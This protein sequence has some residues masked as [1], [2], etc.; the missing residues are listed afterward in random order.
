MTVPG[1]FKCPAESLLKNF[2]AKASET[3]PTQATGSNERPLMPRLLVALRG[4]RTPALAAGWVTPLP[5]GADF[6][7]V[8]LPGSHRLPSPSS[9]VLHGPARLPLGLAGAQTSAVLPGY[10]PIQMPLETVQA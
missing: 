7:H 10:F 1:H 2:P 6:L 4:E 9:G 5:S 8:L 3:P